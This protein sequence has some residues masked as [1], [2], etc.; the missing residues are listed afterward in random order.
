[1]AAPVAVVLGF[2]L[3]AQWLSVGIVAS[4]ARHN[5][6]YYYT[7]GDSTWYYTNAWVL[8][9]GHIPLGY[10]SYG[11]PSL[12]APIARFAGPN[13]LSGLPFVMVLNLL[14]L[15]PVALLCVYG[16][17]K[18]IGGRGFAYL[19]MLGWIAFP[20]ASIPYFYEGYH[21]RYVDQ[22][23]PSALGLV[24][25][26]DFPALVSLLVAAYFAL[27]AVVEHNPKAA[28]MAGLAAGLA[29]T[30]KPANLIFLPAPLV[31]LA[32]ARRPKELMLLCAGLVPA[33][34]GLALWKYRGLG[35]VPAFSQPTATI[36]SGLFAPPPVGGL[37]LGEYFR[38]DWSHLWLNMLQL[39]EYTWSLRMVTWTVVAAVIALLRRSAAVG[40]L[41]GGWLVSFIVLK[42][43]APGVNVADGSFFRYM[44][45]AFPAYFLGLASIALLVPVFGGTLIA[46]GRS[47]GYW[48][49]GTRSWVALFAVAAVATAAPIIAIAAFHPLTAPTAAQVPTT[50][51]YVPAGTFPVSALLNGD[52]SVSLAWPAQS[53]HGT[54]VSYLVFRTSGDHLDCP[55]RPHAASPCTYY[56]DPEH[57]KLV[58]LAHTSTPSFR[59]HPPPQQWVY[60]VAATVS[61]S[62]RDHGGDFLLLSAATKPI[63]VPTF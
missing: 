39:R 33:L 4:I 46:K 58:P 17:A 52:G 60:R 34:A 62:R 15:W 3:L 45:P 13:M 27:K 14:V 22:A 19:A 41:I 30:V 59:D 29:A 51:Q 5:G 61:P 1:M 54:R 7:G 9:H 50:D 21:Q 53:A 43:S 44:V 24:A 36:A 11:Y 2:L 49:G 26:G 56:T 37:R 47:E 18:A 25:T 40:L 55:L 10:I 48:P 38:V 12:L 35:Y 63:N 6:V 20:I 57:G 31:A 16:I 8:A 32:V 42:A 23:L 28:L